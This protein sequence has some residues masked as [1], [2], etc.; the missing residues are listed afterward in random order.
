[1]TEN[2]IIYREIP[3]SELTLN[4]YEVANRLKVPRD[5]DL[6]CAEK[7]KTELEKIIDCKMAAVRVPIKC[8][9]MGTESK[10][11]EKCLK[12][13]NEA[14]IFAVTL[15][16]GVDR[17]LLK[18]S[19]ISPSSAFIID[20]LASAYAEAAAD[21]AQ[22]ILDSIAKTKLRFSPG[23]GDL[24]LEIQP[25]VLD[26]LNAGKLLGVTLTDSLLMKPQ[27][28]ITAIAGIE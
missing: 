20:A 4:I 15:G 25:R 13:S 5:F 16:S 17:L 28:T 24:P 3:T 27:K 23:Y 21:R 9:I 22:D 18:Y 2:N 19:K 26:L 12:D 10:D 14:F 7:C 6:S 11:L 1:M 8:N